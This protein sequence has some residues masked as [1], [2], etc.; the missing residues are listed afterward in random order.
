MVS[1]TFV[2]NIDLKKKLIAKSPHLLLRV[3]LFD[4]LQSK[5]IVI[6]VYQKIRRKQVSLNK[7]NF[8]DHIHK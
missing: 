7:E 8:I 3:F 1:E 4:W 5:S 6:K 2:N